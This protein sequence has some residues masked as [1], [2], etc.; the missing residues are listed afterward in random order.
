M[1]LSIKLCLVLLLGL[2]LLPLPARAQ[3]KKAGITVGQAALGNVFVPSP[4]P[5][6]LPVDL[7]G[8]ADSLS[9]ELFNGWNVLVAH[10][11]IPLTPGAGKTTVQMTLATPGFYVLKSSLLSGNT[12]IAKAVTN[13]AALTPYDLGQ[14]A[15]NPFG[16]DTHYGQNWDPSSVPL[17]ATM[18]AK[19]LRDGSD[20]GV[21]EVQK[22]VMKIPA[23]FQRAMNLANAQ[24]I[25]VLQTLAFGNNLYYPDP[26]LP[27]YQAAP[28]TQEGYDQY[29][30]YCTFI[31]D[32]FKDR[33][34]FFEMWNEYNG[35]FAQG[36]AA[37][38]PEIYAAMIKTAC[39]AI[40][41][42]NPKAFVVG[43]SSVGIPPDWIGETFKQGALNDLDGVSFHPYGYS[44]APEIMEPSLAKLH[45]LVRQYNHGQD[46]SLWS[47]EGGWYLIKSGQLGN[48][49]PITDFV[50]A[51]YLVRAWT[52]MLSQ[53]VSHMFWYLGRD[54][55]AFPNMGLV[56]SDT[57]PRG[58]Y[59]PK[60]IYVA[61]ATLIRQLT[62]FTIARREKSPADIYDYV[63]TKGDNQ[64]SVL[65]SRSP[66]DIALAGTDPVTVTDLFG[67]ATT[68]YPVNGSLNLHLTQAPVYI[69][70]KTG[71]LVLPLFHLQIPAT[72]AKNQAFPAE[73]SVSANPAPS[74]LTFLYGSQQPKMESP[75][76]K[77][78]ASVFPFRLDPRP[79]VEE[80]IWTPFKLDS[81][82]KA[83]F[84]GS[85]HALLFDPV[86][87]DRFPRL[88]GLD[89]LLES[90]TNN[91]RGNA[92]IIKSIHYVINKE[93]KE[94]A[95]NQ[96][97]APGS[98]HDFQL[99]V[100]HLQP[101]TL[102]PVSIVATLDN[103]TQ[104]TATNDVSYN[105]VP[106]HT[107]RVDG[108]LDDWDLSHGID[109]DHATYV[110]LKEPRRDAK[111]LGGKIY[112]AADDHNLY[113]AAVIEDDVFFQNYTGANV[114]RGD[115]VQIAITPLMP[116]TAG[117]WPAGPHEFEIALTPKGP[118]MAEAGKL[119][120]PDVKIAIK[121]QGTQTIYE[122]ALPW[123]DIDGVKGPLPQFSWATYVNDND[124][125]WRK[126][127]LQWGDIKT[128]S[129]MQ[130][131]YFNSK[132]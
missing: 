32:H 48:R 57:D 21:V 108:S 121:R 106:R 12:I 42:V 89:V 39:P 96:E 19:F 64:C 4:N 78:N 81:D 44:L 28:Y 72:L 101:F 38:R 107:I 50:Q 29:T 61:Y 85:H 40:K 13:L 113:M 2:I 58:K 25:H 132:P 100:D 34:E 77:G 52:V 69:S 3:E 62:G 112:F 41:K 125:H 75:M 14:V 15:D 109:L 8:R 91:S 9:W 114:W 23:S 124:G 94:L 56:T 30:R 45:A 80:E 26:A 27:S 97:L 122:A 119:Q 74:S 46:K 5:I 83:I 66:A 76:Q 24:H 49:E 35:D 20:W 90:I 31:V 110:K 79:G 67:A 60:P 128:L 17:F 92:A 84:L 130:P 127:Y 70:G 126:G 63:F 93:T 99:P 55:G 87:A 111:D 6:S 104:V 123:T 36:P 88:K 115:S 1:S 82:G 129:G 71:P 73:L 18:G 10:G 33:P 116:W 95:V 16:V 118:S 43:L 54:F 59:A 86:T 22:G 7:S 65:W 68:L 117:E 131:F 105:P 37:G 53:N 51:E 120:R 98:T 102:Y 47:T 11:K 103:G